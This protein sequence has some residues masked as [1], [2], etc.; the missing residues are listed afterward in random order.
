MKRIVV[1][2]CLT[3]LNSIAADKFWVRFGKEKIT[4]RVK[5]SGFITKNCK[6]CKAIAFME[7]EI[8]LSQ[9]EINLKNPFSVACKKAGGKVRVGKLY[10]GHSQ[11]FCFAK[12]GS[13]ISTNILHFKLKK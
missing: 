13:T 1:L 6:K 8:Q 10:S 12:D 5:G 9:E 7:K 3:S 11:S 2:M 4:L